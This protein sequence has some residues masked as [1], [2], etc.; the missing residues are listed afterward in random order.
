MKNA[1]LLAD[2]A[3]APYL[4]RLADLPPFQLKSKKMVRSR[5]KM[6]MLRS[7]SPGSGLRVAPSRVVTDVK[8]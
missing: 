2:G 3:G 4:H 6:S 5:V 8:R 1:A 7:V